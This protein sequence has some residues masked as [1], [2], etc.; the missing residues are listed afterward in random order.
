MAELKGLRPLIE[1][2]NI[3]GKS[4][5][6]TFKFWLEYCEMAT[7][8]LDFIAAERQSDWNL[9]LELF[10]EMLYY[11]RAYDHYKYFIWGL[12]YIIDMKK[13][14]DNHP[15]LHENFINGY[16][17]VSR[18]KNKSSFN[19][20]STDMALEQSLNKD[21]KTKGKVYSSILVI[22]VQIDHT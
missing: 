11:D 1:H 7:L 5:S 10:Q 13:L 9:H 15:D 19:C 21:T 3:I 17:A 18:A 14:P 8:L 16:H 6:E 2:F 20:V 4:S 12:I 22:R